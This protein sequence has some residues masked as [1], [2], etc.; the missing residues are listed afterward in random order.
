MNEMDIA[1]AVALAEDELVE[2]AAPGH[3]KPKKKWI[4]SAAAIAACLG[5]LLAVIWP[6]LPQSPRYDGSTPYVIDGDYLAGKS[7]VISNS[8]NVIT[9]QFPT[10]RNIIL[11]AQV[12]YGPVTQLLNGLPGFNERTDPGIELFSHW[13]STQYSFD[14]R[15]HFTLFQPEFVEEGFTSQAIPQGYNYESAL[16]QIEE[17]ASVAFQNFRY[18]LA[19]TLTGIEDS[20]E[21]YLSSQKY[22]S[23]PKSFARVGL[24]VEKVSQVRTYHFENFFCLLNGRFINDL[25]AGSTISFVIYCYDGVWYALPQYMEN[26]LSVDML[27]PNLDNL[28]GE[29]TVGGIVTEVGEHYF[30]LYG[31]DAYCTADGTDV[32]VG[33][34]VEVVRYKF[35]VRVMLPDTPIGE[36]PLPSVDI[37]GLE[38][39]VI[40]LYGVKS[41]SPAEM[42]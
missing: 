18:E 9:K 32:R 8:N 12:N 14:Y 21:L 27:G 31:Q 16:A 4:R 17:V 24:D 11:T 38:G 5:L 34:F 29:E 3:R 39:D 28:I 7:V 37:A 42:P 36:T 33:D 10:F 6:Q 30:I 26:D 40:D 15:Q 19:F 25:D 22:Q 1:R 13:L 41:V 35:E 2:M 23:F 20:T